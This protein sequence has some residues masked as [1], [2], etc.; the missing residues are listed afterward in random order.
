MKQ[1]AGTM[2]RQMAEKQ[3]REVSDME[4]AHEATLRALESRRYD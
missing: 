2:F 1:R 4:R 3:A